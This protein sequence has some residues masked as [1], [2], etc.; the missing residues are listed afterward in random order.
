[1]KSLKI[2]S[3]DALDAAVAD[4][5]RLKIAHTKRLADRDDAIAA[6]E[7]EHEA[8]IQA[9]AADIADR[10][11]AIRD[12][13]DAHRAE[14]FPVNK[15][16]ETGLAVFGFEYTPPRVET[17]NRKIKWADVLER[18]RR[19]RWGLAYIRS[20][21]SLDKEALLADREKLTPEQCTAAGIQF[22]QDEQFFLRPKPETAANTEAQ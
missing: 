6:V 22:A 12:Y 1:M 18:L 9:S 14:L 21:E 13:C 16:R 20:K 17:A 4:C 10:E 5:V 11:A 3:T 2:T 15:S 19:A 7:K 8:G